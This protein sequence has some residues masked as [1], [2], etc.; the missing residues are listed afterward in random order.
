[1]KA[2]T[3]PTPGN[4]DYHVTDARGYYAYFGP[5]AGQRGEGYYSMD[6]GGWHIVALNSNCGEVGGCGAG[7]PQEEWLADDLAAHA[8]ACTLAY[9]HHPR[10]S[11]GYHGNGTGSRL[12][13]GA[14]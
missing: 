3:R 10:F 4:H 11:S 14:L 5:L 7:S 2:L 6:V 13:A 12:L 1:V 8:S 9:W